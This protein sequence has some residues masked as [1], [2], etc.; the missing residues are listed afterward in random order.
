MQFMKNHTLLFWIG[1]IQLVCVGLGVGLI[2]IPF[3][4]GLDELFF[5]IGCGLISS[6][7][8]SFPIELLHYFH[9]AK[10]EKF[11]TQKYFRYYARLF[12]ELKSTVSR[13][14]R[15][16]QGEG[17]EKRN[18]E[19]YLR[20]ALDDGSYDN[21][22]TF[23]HND[24][25]EEITYRIKNIREASIDL[26]SKDSH[27]LSGNRTLEQK[28]AH[29]QEQSSLAFQIEHQV[30]VSD[31]SFLAERIMEMVHLFVRVFPEYKKA[32]LEPYTHKDK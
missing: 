4:K 21:P 26:L 29:L 18:F 8:V 1:C 5:S 2:F 31:Y 30:F 14:Y 19:W 24:A 17:K 9:V 11:A 32:F 7:F 25:L 6:V 22:S 3:K 12:L 10:D 28:I 23:D 16:T 13:I 15:D 20:Y 27:N